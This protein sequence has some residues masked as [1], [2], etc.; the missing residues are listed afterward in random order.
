MSK[1]L[2]GGKTGR[3]CDAVSGGGGL[4]RREGEAGRRWGGENNGCMLAQGSDG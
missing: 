3:K 4:G 1:G 2:T